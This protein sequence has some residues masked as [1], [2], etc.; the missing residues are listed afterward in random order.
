MSR[1]APPGDRP[2]RPEDVDP[3]CAALPETWF[4]TT[5]GDVPTWLVLHAMRG[6]ER[7]GRGFVLYRHPSSTAI[8][9]A[10]GEPYT[11]LLVVQTPSAAAKEELVEAE[12]PFFTVPHFDRSHAVLVSLSRLGEIT[13]AELTEVIADA[14]RSCAAP[15]LLREHDRA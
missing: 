4:G 9:P 11:D 2:A 5:W 15:A 1:A 7:R 13:R 12:G 3:I 8:D 6:G 14:W 10:T